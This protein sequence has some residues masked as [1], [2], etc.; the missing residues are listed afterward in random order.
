VEW[1]G[2]LS[3]GYGIADEIEVTK[4]K[5]IRSPNRLLAI[6]CQQLAVNAEENSRYEEAS[7]FRYWAMD[8][9]R[10]EKKGFFS[11]FRLHW[12]YWAVSGYGERSLRAFIFLIGIWLLFAFL[13]TQVGFLR[14]E[15]KISSAEDVMTAKTDE[16]GTPLRPLNA[17]LYS[18]GVITLQKPDPKPATF[19]SQ[20]LI[21]IETFLGPLQVALLALA[22]RRQFMR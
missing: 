1:V 19:T 17:A 18:L 8:A 10:R 15:P 3:G 13:Y 6:A 16:T 22:I 5:H 20:T 12:F 7:K 21:A 2:L 4:R 9:R 14:W 11:I